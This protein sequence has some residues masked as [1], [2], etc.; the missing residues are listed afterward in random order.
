MTQRHHT[1]IFIAI[2][3]LQ[4]V[5]IWSVHYL[6]TVDGP[7]HVYNA[8]V[9]HELVSGRS[10]FLS[11]TF[12]VNWS[13][14]PNWIGSAVMALLMTIVPATIAEKIFVSAIVLLFSLAMWLYAGAVDRR[15]AIAAFLALPFTYNWLLQAGFYNF[16]IGV[17]MAFI[18]IAI[19]WRRRDQPNATTIVSVALLL[20]V[21]YFAHPMAV[22]FACGAIGLMWLTTHRDIKLLGVF[23]PVLPLLFWYVLQILMRSR[24]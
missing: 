4:L 8:W 18:T 24:D 13:P 15:R 10:A 9:L 16:S 6:P 17:A 22:L 11:Q 20:I 12:R 5:P 2:V 7:S 1:T 3:I 23:L 21:C 14:Q 19:W